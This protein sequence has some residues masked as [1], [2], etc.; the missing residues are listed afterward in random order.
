MSPELAALAGAIAGTVCSAL[1]FVVGY[2][3]GWTKRDTQAGIHED[4]WIRAISTAREE[5][6]DARALIATLLKQEQD[7]CPPEQHAD[8]KTK[9]EPRN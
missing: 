1:G 8:E 9:P 6:D 2:A 7:A 3:F 5:R 4:R